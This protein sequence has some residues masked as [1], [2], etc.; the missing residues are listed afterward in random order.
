MRRLVILLPFLLAGCSR[1]QRDEFGLDRLKAPSGFKISVFGEAPSARMMAFSPGGVLLV[2]CSDEGVV[3]ALPDRRRTGRAE[4]SVTLLDGLN[5]PHGLAFENGF[6]FVAEK[7]KVT[8]YDWDEA[9]LRATNSKVLTDLPRGGGH[10]TR[11]LLFADGKMYVST[12][13]S[14]NVCVESDKRRAAVT[15]FN[16]DGTGQKMFAWG[17][18]NS[19]GLALNPRTGTIW[20]TDNGR[21]MLGE[22]VPP[23]EIN[24]LAAGGDFGWP[25]CY[26]K[27]T[28]DTT[29]VKPGDDRCKNTIPAKVEIQAHSAPLGL[30]FASSTM[31]P[32]EYRNDL[33]VALHGSWNRKIPTGYKVIR[34]RLSEKSEVLGVEDFIAG[35]LR[36]GETR[37]GAWMGR[38]VGIVF[39]ADGSMY[40]SDDSAGKVYRVTYSR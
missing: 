24:D 1:A 8:R 11:T 39:A 36:P 20:A 32:A 5:E 21:D 29:Q 19:V 25:W 16:P 31:F 13:S 26:G 40:I 17:L 3:V 22:D 28:P 27:Q 33:F 37:H 12:G 38:P 23:D 18:R 15:Q 35:W 10:R 9:H 4:S 14:C 2:S 34:I 6:L 7:D 30:A